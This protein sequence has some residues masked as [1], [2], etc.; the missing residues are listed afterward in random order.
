MRMTPTPQCEVY[1][2][3]QLAGLKDMNRYVT[4]CHRSSPASSLVALDPLTSPMHG[5]AALG[6]G[7]KNFTTL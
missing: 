5:V 1:F 7:Q 3:S 6:V 4:S 2:T